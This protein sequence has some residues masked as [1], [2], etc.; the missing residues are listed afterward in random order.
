MSRSEEVR[1]QLGRIAIVSPY[2]VDVPGGVQS[3]VI[4][5][6]KAVAREYELELLVV[7]P[8]SF[9]RSETIGRTRIR[10]LGLGRTV[11]IAWNRSIA[12]ITLDPRVLPRLRYAL[13]AF[14]PDVVH[15]HEPLAPILSLL[16]TLSGTKGP[17]PAIAT[18]H[19][20]SERAKVLALAGPLVRRRLRSTYAR[21]LSVGPDTTRIQAQSLGLDCQE[22]MEI[23]NAV[24]L[25]VVPSPVRRSAPTTPSVVFVG[26]LEPRKGGRILMHALERIEQPIQVDIVGD[27]PE[28]AEYERIA[29]GL[30]QHRITF[31][32]R[33]SDSTRDKVTAAADVLVA[34]ALG[35]EAFGI[36]LLEAMAV[37]TA[38]VASDIDGYSML[39]EH[40]S[41]A[42]VARAGDVD[43]TAAAIKLV[44]SDQELRERI[45]A[46]GIA[47]ARRF[48]WAEQAPA[49][50]QVY[51]Q[52][53]DS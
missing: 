33:A 13:K 8:G 41:N 49:V 10:Y 2:D 16:F 21:L 46:G 45:V 7:S 9:D 20:H 17:P 12:P 23:P 6:A 22:F 18:H 44:L 29:S 42:V 51:Q 31:H 32:G 4:S 30:C 47:T 38:V 36:V 37:G 40:G 15:V 43:A 26:R 1:G 14:A 35:G 48:S 53:L 11:G 24:D 52:I 34:P 50:L 27:G 19:M 3:H 5:F 25:D 39:A 28:R